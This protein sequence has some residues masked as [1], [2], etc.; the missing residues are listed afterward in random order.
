MRKDIPLSGKAFCDSE[1]EALSKEAIEKR[2]IH[3]LIASASVVFPLMAL[4]V[5]NQSVEAKLS[6]LGTGTL[7]GA[8]SAYIA[9]ARDGLERRLES[10]LALNTDLHKSEV[11]NRYAFAKLMGDITRDANLAQELLTKLP[12]SA[13]I[14]YAQRNQLP[15]GY[16][17]H[18]LQPA[19]E[20]PASIE[21]SP[22][23]KALPVAKPDSDVVDLHID[24]KALS[25][26]E[27]VAK[28]YP[29][30]IRVN[31]GWIDELIESSTRH[32]MK[33]RANHHF[34]IFAAT[35]GGK[36]TLAGVL[37][38]GIA[39]RSQS[40]AIIAIHDAKKIEGL[41]DLTRWLCG[42]T[43][44]IDGYKAADKWADLMD[45]LSHQQ[46][47]DASNKGGGNCDGLREL[48][49]IQDELNTCYG[50]GK[51]LVNQ[52]NVDTVRALQEQWQFA[53][54]NLAGSKGHIIF[55]GQTPL[56]G[57]TGITLAMQNNLALIMLGNTVSYILEPKNRANYIRNVSEEILDTMLKTAELMQSSGI[58]YCLVRPTVGNPYLAIVP[59]FDVDSIGIDAGVDAVDCEENEDEDLW[60]DIPPQ[61]QL[62]SLIENEPTPASID[63]ETIIDLMR[64]WCNECFDSYGVYP[65]DEQI[66]QAWQAQT[67]EILTDAG[68]KLLI[69]KL[70]S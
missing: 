51:G 28:K 59:E 8:A 26:I 41:K 33:K 36:S 39:D 65:T 45:R 70:I 52:I 29:D 54:T 68:L 44:K 67:G 64:D 10:L 22:V 24:R 61:Q 46:M 9:R 60:G 14:E 1:I 32:D 50:G 25:V 2:W 7:Y 48:V 38:K 34:G 3:G 40:P 37:A 49:L 69:E 18:L 57:D 17:N 31:A 42:H 63:I 27:N 35:Q 20:P 62:S 43:Y 30:Y 6:Q 13:A 23:C 55:M 11:I 16:F 53:I 19:N 4:I 5:P 66:S 56:A 12:P 58:R 21:P 47:V 15:I